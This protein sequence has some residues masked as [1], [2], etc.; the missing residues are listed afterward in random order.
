MYPWHQWCSDLRIVQDRDSMSPWSRFIT[1]RYST[2]RSVHKHTHT[3]THTTHTTHHHLPNTTCH[4]YHQIPSLS[5]FPSCTD[6]QIAFTTLYHYEIR[7]LQIP[8]LALPVMHWFMVYILLQ[9][10]LCRLTARTTQALIDCHWW[11]WPACVLQR[12]QLHQSGSCSKKLILSLFLS[13]LFTMWNSTTCIVWFSWLTKAFSLGWLL[14]LWKRGKQKPNE[15]CTYNK[16]KIAECKLIRK[17]EQNKKQL[18]TNDD[19]R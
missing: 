15:H 1:Q 9:G 18:R 19:F 8:Y 6:S 16:L 2:I 3:N 12:Q 14:N 17:V 7:A 11:K 5:H 13:K 10:A 4:D